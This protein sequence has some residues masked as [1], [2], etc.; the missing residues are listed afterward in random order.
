MI[1]S[2]TDGL[3]KGIESR[4]FKRYSCDLGFVVL[5]MVMVMESIV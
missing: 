1:A 4:S 5:I 2:Y 3:N